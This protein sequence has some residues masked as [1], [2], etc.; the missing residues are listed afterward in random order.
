[1]PPQ[2]LPNFAP[3]AVMRVLRR[4]CRHCGNYNGVTV[5]RGR[6]FCSVCWG[7]RGRA[8]PVKCRRHPH[9]ARRPAVIYSPQP[10]KRA[11]R[12]QHGARRASGG[13]RDDGGGDPSSPPHRQQSSRRIGAVV[14]AIVLA[15]LVLVPAIVQQGNFTPAIHAAIVE[16]KR[17]R[18]RGTPPP[19]DFDLE[20]L[21][22]SALL[23]AREVAA[24]LRYAVGTIDSW[25]SKPGHPLRYTW[26]KTLGP[27]AGAGAWLGDSD[28][29]ADP[30]GVVLVAEGIETALSV[31]QLFGRPTWAAL[32]TALLQQL[33]LPENHRDIVICADRDP[34]GALA[35][36][37]AARRFA[38]QGRRVRVVQPPP[39][40]KDFNNFL[41]ERRS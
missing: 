39:G 24:V 38:A 10:R 27:I 2:L 25:R 20:T 41:R 21:P 36:H 19:A 17:R 6:I 12:R 11:P 29:S 18:F 1:M 35:A 4:P 34:A 15:A 33:E 14:L 3:P 26:V 40:C 37:A 28:V 16:N 23:R 32:G 22:D 13:Q 31:M 30:E 9:P 7:I 5:K 8:K